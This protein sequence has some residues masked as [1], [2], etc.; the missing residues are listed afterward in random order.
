M[1]KSGARL[2][3]EWFHGDAE[4]PQ[5]VLT[6][7][8]AD[9]FKFIYPETERLSAY[10]RSFPYSFDVWRALSWV[11]DDPTMA[12][13]ILEQG[14]AILR[15]HNKDVA[16]LLEKTKRRITIAGVEVWIAN[17]PYTMASDAGHALSSNGELFGAVYYVNS[18]G[19]AVV[20]LRS[21]E[22]GADVSLIAQH[23]GGGGHKHAAAFTIDSLEQL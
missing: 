23:Y 3:W 1:T 19:Q 5:L 9:L 8:D 18:K 21:A 17:L 11:L 12:P 10:I 7:E 14:N 20:S 13:S 2:T 16:E 22:D 15:K 6:V 4:I